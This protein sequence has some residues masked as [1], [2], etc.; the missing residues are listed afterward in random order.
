[1]KHAPAFVRTEGLHGGVIDDSHGQAEGR[2]EVEADPAG[3]EVAGLGARTV[4]ADQAGITDRDGLI[5]PVL[6]HLPDE[7]DHLRWNEL[8]A[9]R[10]LA[11]LR[12]S[13][14]KGFEFGA[15][16]VDD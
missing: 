11:R 14:G 2:G 10:S 1:E 5:F 6:G 12:L 16:D 13:R 4:V 3:A 9:G 8:L 7:L 15:A